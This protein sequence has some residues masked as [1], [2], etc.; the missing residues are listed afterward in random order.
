MADRSW[1]LVGGG[2]HCPEVSGKPAY[3]ATGKVWTVPVKLKA[4][5]SY[6]FMLNADRFKGF[7]SREGVPLAPIKVSFKTGPLKSS[8]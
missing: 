4:N 8:E 2:P 6:E 7:Q 5:W 1:S 3:D